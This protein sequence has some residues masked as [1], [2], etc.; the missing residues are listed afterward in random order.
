MRLQ[1]KTAII[2]GGA[3]SLG[4]AETRL[5]VENGA[6]VVFV[7]VAADD[8]KALEAEIRESGGNASFVQADITT[9]EGWDAIVARA[10]DEFGGLDILVNNAG[11]SSLIN[12]DNFDLDTWETMVDVNMKAPFLGIRAALPK[13]IERGGGS[14]VNV[15]SIG[16]LIAIDPGHV[17]Y[18]ASKAGL[19]GMTRVIAGRYGAQNIRANNVY[20]G[21]MPP[22]RVPGGPAS[23]SSS[24][25][26]VA[27]LTAL[28]RVGV[29]DDIAYAVL[30]FASDESSYVTGA[31][32]VVD[33]GVVIR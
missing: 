14:I 32:L 28:G 26:A 5:F 15:C 24:R 6:N 25:D 13:L 22:M 19:A 1:G 4:S 30:Y 23:S 33:G 11:V 16:A 29:S 10:V 21:A 3:G 18:T 20:P 9:V 17:G 27:N 31:D 7:D 12:N 8:G 2:T